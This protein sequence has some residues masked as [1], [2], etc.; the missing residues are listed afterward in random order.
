MKKL[1]K[2]DKRYLALF[3][4]IPML[5]A[6]FFSKITFE[7]A[8][9][10]M[11]IGIAKVFFYSGERKKNVDELRGLLSED[12]NKK[13]EIL[14]RKIKFSTK[15][16]IYIGG[17]MIL[18]IFISVFLPKLNGKITILLMISMIVLIKKSFIYFQQKIYERNMKII[19]GEIK[20][21]DLY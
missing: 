12:E 2:T 17:E 1:S 20:I 9:S 7:F 19:N 18:L 3:I 5:S 4:A 21:E 13:N 14:N 10:T 15:L 11:L 16:L 8:F 6:I